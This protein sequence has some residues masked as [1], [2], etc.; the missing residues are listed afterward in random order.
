MT[1]PVEKFTV[2]GMRNGSPVFVTWSAG[3]LVGDP[4]TVDLIEV[5]ADL[6]AVTAGDMSPSGGAE[7]L[8]DPS[9]VYGLCNAVIDRVLEIE[10]PDLEDRLAGPA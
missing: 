8:A 10:P 9:R 2:R 1:V 4:P 5:E 7:V 6:A 3:Q